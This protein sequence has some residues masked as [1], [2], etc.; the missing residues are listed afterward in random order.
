MNRRTWMKHSLYGIGSIGIGIGAGASAY[1]ADVAALR[2]LTVLGVELQD[3][4]ENPLTKAAQEIRLR[5][6]LVLLRNELTERNLYTLLDA[7]PAQDVEQK[8]RSQHEFIY[9]CDHCAAEIGRTAKAELIM[10]PWVQ[11]VSELI[12]NFNVQIVDVR[13]EKV[14]FSKSVDMRGNTDQ[15][16]SRAVRYLVRDMAEKRAL[17]PRYGH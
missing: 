3:D 17:N 4:Q 10:T 14:I 5:D 2:T 8:L 6:T 7:T 15:S 12:L 16:W 13:T 1:A 11:K 9:R